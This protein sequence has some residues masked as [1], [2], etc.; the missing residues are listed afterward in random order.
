MGLPNIAAYA[1]QDVHV[2]GALLTCLRPK[3]YCL[4]PTATVRS[5]EGGGGGIAPSSIPGS[6]R[7]PQFGPTDP[8]VHSVQVLCFVGRT[9]GL[10]QPAK[11][12]AP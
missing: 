7:N 9:T 4:L 1:Y 11:P 12:P 5:G 10:G 2:W 8:L 6:P 3:K